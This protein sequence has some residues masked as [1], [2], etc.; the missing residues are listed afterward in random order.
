LSLLSVVVAGSVL[1]DRNREAAERGEVDALDLYGVARLFERAGDAAR[2][3]E[4]LEKALEGRLPAEVSHTAR[5]KLSHHFKKK[6]DW[7]KA[8][9]LWQRMSG[10]D[11]AYCFR[12][13]SMYY[14]HKAKDYKEAMRAAEEGMAVTIGRSLTDRKDFEK[15]IER[16][17]GKIGKHGGGKAK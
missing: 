5:K 16:L 6:Q 13:L 2:S 4:L 17:K 14:E 15:R 12:E 8:V 11:Q 10:G 7:D 1:V 9:S 3:A